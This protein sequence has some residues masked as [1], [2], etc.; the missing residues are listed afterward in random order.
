MYMKFKV[1]LYTISRVLFGLYLVVH[2]VYNVFIYSEFLKE[3]NAYFEYTEW[4]THP[5]IESLAPL[6]PFEEFIL[7]MFLVL[8][9]FTKEVLICALLLFS[10]ISLFL[11]DANF[12]FL[13]IMHAMFF[14]ISLILLQHKNYNIKSMD[15]NRDLYNSI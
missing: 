10:F 15:Y 11:L 5:L 2:S 4:F 6:V 7:G 1:Y 14:V 8:G 9:I 3:I 12:P 13:A